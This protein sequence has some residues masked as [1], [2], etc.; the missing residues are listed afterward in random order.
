M[1]NYQEISKR[2][3]ALRGLRK[4]LARRCAVALGLV[5]ILFS[6]HPTAAVAQDKITFDDHAKPILMQ[7]CSS[8]HNNERTEGDLDVTNYTALMQGGGSGD[9][10]EPGSST[11]SYLFALVTHADKPVMP[12]GGQKI[13]DPQI[14]VLAKWIDGGA[15]E[16]SGS[17][18]IKRKKVDLSVVVNPSKRPEVL[19]M[20]M[21]MPKEPVLTTS[22]PSTVH[23][24]AT[25]PWAKLAAVTSPQQVLLYNTESRG[26][27]GV[28][29]FPEGQ[30]EIVRF[31]RNGSLLLIGGG[32]GASLGK[33]VLW[34]V[35]KGRRVAVVGDEPDSVLA[36]DVNPDQ[37]VVACGG[38]KKVVRVYN[39]DGTLQYEIVKHTDWVTAVQFSPD[40][41]FLA[42]ADR[43]G[44]LY[45]WDAA[46][47]NELF[48]LV[49]HKKSVT[50]LDWRVDS[51]ILASVSEENAIRIWELNK[52]KQVKTW[53]AHGPGV[54][55]VEFTREGNLVTG[56][57]DHVVK[58]WKQDGNLIKQYEK[59]GDQIVSSSFCDES[60]HVL[61]GDWSGNLKI[62]KAGDG[63][64]VGALSVNPPPLA[65]RVGEVEK[66]LAQA[67]EVFSPKEALRKE[68]ANKLGAAQAATNAE[69]GALKML[70]STLAEN[71]KALADAKQQLQSTA[72]QQLA[73]RTELDAKKKALPSV[74]K[75]HDQAKEA[76]AS[77]PE[78]QELATTV[79][80]LHGKLA[81]I[82]A[83]IGELES[84]AKQSLQMKQT[85]EE[86]VNQLTQKVA[87]LTTNAAAS[88]K[89]IAKYQTEVGQLADVLKT[90]AAEATQAKGEVDR[91]TGAL[92]YWNGEIQFKQKLVA[93][94]E[95]RNSAAKV[96]E[97]KLSVVDSAKQKLNEAQAV[98]DAAEQDRLKAEEQV[99]A[100][101]QQ[102]E[103]L[104]T[105]K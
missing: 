10:I 5:G 37:T 102:I 55:D 29:P 4:L 17:K 42:T 54:S 73:W 63:A 7:R 89:L 70:E 24:I 31:S 86:Q 6:V 15:L 78:D 22:R 85:T 43:A 14:Q 40:G 66:L 83:R 61:G 26:L 3:I 32:K 13:P 92:S 103:S 30:P 105:G 48:T 101:E 34:D 36:S 80:Q 97:E 64:E 76:A 50:D 58:L 8:C 87:E 67:V 100:V 104:K 98:V 65:S 99:K 49:G 72:E 81:Q 23:S 60:Q 19:P 82:G 16:N 57:R 25:S 45:V 27:M 53:A 52:G 88:N 91:L 35:I 20:P 41:K 62:W 2:F 51:K 39:V 44:G 28:V 47:G 84:A 56:G 74:Q 71:Q 9:V 33:V 1:I 79:K 95:S 77:L 59:M 90:Q 21:R 96:E 18:A 93:L 69:S 75:S 11:D 68:T 46:S 38:P 12:P 94:E